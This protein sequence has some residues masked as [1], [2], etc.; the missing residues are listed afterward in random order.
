[1]SRRPYVGVSGVM[2]ADESWACVTAWREAWASVGREPTHDLMLGALVSAK[3]LAGLSNK[4]PLRYPP[5]H[6]VAGCFFD[7][8]GVLNLVHYASDRPPSSDTLFQLHKVA[9][10]RCHGF[11]FNL[12]WPER[13]DLANLLGHCGSR[14]IVLQ[15]GP[16]ML[17]EIGD[18]ASLAARLE[19]YSR[20]FVGNDGDALATDV[21]LDASGGNG[22]PIDAE[23]AAWS[24]HVIA[25][26]CPGMGTGIAGGL[27]AETL[28]ETVGKMVRAGCSIDA[29]RLVRDDA[30]GGGNLVMA[31]MDAYL[32]R[33]VALTATS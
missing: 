18:A 21:L 26:H 4:Y 33:A 20:D 7:A 15:A 8:P 28:D 3:T 19:P 17:A 31:K 29:E 16:K 10:R 32:R 30:N 1:M 9:G 22:L 23:A 27:C 5:I 6:E 11:Q 12:S 25:A 13:I 14:R 24:I 2:S